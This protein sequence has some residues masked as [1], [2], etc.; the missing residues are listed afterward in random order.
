MYTCYLDESG[1]CGEKVNP[2]QPVEIIFGVLIDLSKLTKAQKQY[3]QFIDIFNE[4]KIKIS[5]FKACDIYKG[6]KQFSVLN[7]N[8]RDALFELLLAWGE[9]NKC[10]YIVSPI[11]SKKHFDLV[12][13]TDPMANILSFPFEAGV[14]NITLA[15]QKLQKTKEKNK[16]RTFIIIDE[17]K[18][19]DENFIRLLENDLSYTD[20]YTAY[21]E[22]K[23]EHRLNQIID[24]PFFTKSHLTP[25][26]QLA[27]S[28]AFIVRK[29][30][31]LNSFNFKENYP[32]EKGKISR[33]YK[34]LKTRKV[35][36]TI[37][38]PSNPD[39]SLCNYYSNIRPNNWDPKEW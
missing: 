19:H 33:W 1:H 35:S 23:E 15:I 10:R 2:Q 12:S 25:I 20:V 31:E 16:G 7:S 6:Y 27:D 9:D 17:Q 30:I 28:G 3:Q 29:Y 5:E 36:H 11:D 18:K 8:A 13:K 24:I 22:K 37:I 38:N 32:G 21:N 26:I 34:V 39:D 14:M 4:H